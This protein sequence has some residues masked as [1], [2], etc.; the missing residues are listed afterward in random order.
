MSTPSA[1]SPRARLA[2][3]IPAVHSSIYWRIGFSVGDQVVL[4]ELP[5]GNGTEATL[6]LRDIEMGRARQYARVDQVAC[7]RTSLRPVAFRATARPRMR[8]LRRSV[9]V[10]RASSRSMGTAPSR[11]SSSIVRAK[12]A[13]RSNANRTVG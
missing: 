11:S 6:I 2:A 12:P 8:R 1:T 10:G 3:G 13:L 7:P 5:K 9:S 4:I